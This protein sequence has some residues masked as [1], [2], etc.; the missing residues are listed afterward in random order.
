MEYH[1][2][3]HRGVKPFSCDKCDFSTH[4]LTQLTIVHKGRGKCPNAPTIASVKRSKLDQCHRCP[5]LNTGAHQVWPITLFY[6]V[7]F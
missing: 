7:C 6:S 1:T 4:S 3:K 2:N 5:E